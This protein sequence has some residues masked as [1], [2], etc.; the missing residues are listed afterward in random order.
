MSN[1][2]GGGYIF[3]YKEKAGSDETVGAKRARKGMSK[4]QEEIWTEMTSSEKERRAEFTDYLKPPIPLVKG[5][6]TK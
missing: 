3:G 6:P 1:Y 4:R 5:R 2:I